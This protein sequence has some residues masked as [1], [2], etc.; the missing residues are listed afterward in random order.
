MA[1]GAGPAMAKEI[2]VDDDGAQCPNATQT[3]IQAAV[4]A[5]DPGDKIKVCAGN[6]VEQVRI[7]GSGK[8]G[9]KLEAQKHT[10]LVQSQAA[11]PTTEAIIRYPAAAALLPDAEKFIVRVRTAVGVKIT[12]FRITGSSGPLLGNSLR[13]GV[14]VDGNGEAQ[15]DHNRITEIR[16]IP[17]SGAQNGVAVQVGRQ[18]EGEV[19][20]AKID[21]NLIDRYQKN[22]PT[23][24]NVGSFAEI[25]HN[26]IIGQNPASAQNGVQVSRGATGDVHHNEISENSFGG[27]PAA[28]TGAGVL[29]FQPAVGGVKVSHNEAFLN[30]DNISLSNADGEEIA[31][32]ELYDSQLYDG[33]FVDVNSTGN[34][35]KD[36]KA[37]NNAEHDCHDDSVGTGTAG[38]ANEWKGNRGVTQTPAGICKP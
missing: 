8:N 34:L 22:G 27:D 28:G 20:T 19:G 18:A 5:A 15:I 38:T 9:L 32:N 30:D 35:I 3:S 1:L 14:K 10:K 23:V 26:V 24:D 36:N 25:D 4:T 29:L 2:R 21:H 11:D 33:L 16:D 17:L 37:Y 6:Y 12:G 7:D 13:F 31:H